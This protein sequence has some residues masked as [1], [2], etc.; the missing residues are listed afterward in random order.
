M[1]MFKNILMG[2]L[3]MVSLH[4]L[5]NNQKIHPIA[6]AMGGIVLK[7]DEINVKA[8]NPQI[9][10]INVVHSAAIHISAQQCPD[11][12]FGWPHN[13]CT[14]TYNNITSPILQGIHKAWQQTDNNAYLGIMVNGGNFDLTSEF[15]NGDS[16]FY[17]A[18]GLFLW[19]L[20]MAS[21]D[22]IYKDFVDTSFFDELDANTYGPDDL[23][24]A[25]WIAS[26]V[27]NRQ[28]AWVNLLPWEFASLPLIA[29]RHC[30]T[31]QATL[32]EQAILDN[33]NNLDDT[34]PNTVYSDFIGVA[35][36]VW[37]LAAVNR[38]NFPAIVAPLHN[39]NGFSSLKQ[40]ADFLVNNQNVDGS[41]YWHSNIATPTNSDK[42]TQT[43]A[44]A[45]L[46]LIKANERL[47]D[48][49]LPAINLGQNFLESM[50][51]QFGGF[52]SFPG[53]S[54]NIEVES[55]ALTALATVGVY[56]RIYRSGLECY[57]E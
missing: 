41:W 3:I 54:E 29:N 56:D 23:D 31:A 5:A 32:F 44:Y 19:D 12:G 18:S 10:D 20:S 43:T 8:W 37:G 36:G 11:G 1:I 39:I 24:T 14:A 28:G 53:G 26:T 47:A 48:D 45:V 46:A 9:P 2:S 34:S 4:S 13:D 51:D 33:L 17:T 42:D 49:Y 30:R 21:G 27:T 35:G 38:Q 6:T 15:T 40:L 52:P 7:V 22:S 25:G 16:R 55:E 57:S 50:Q